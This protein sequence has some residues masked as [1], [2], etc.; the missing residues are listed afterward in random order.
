M[1]ELKVSKE[2]ED[3]KE[4]QPTVMD[5]VDTPSPSVQNVKEFDDS[6]EARQ[7]ERKKRREQRQQEL[8]TVNDTKVHAENGTAPAASSLAVAQEVEKPSTSATNGTAELDSYEARK[9][10]RRKARE[11]RLKAAAARV[12]DEKPKQSY[13]EKKAIEARKNTM[14]SRKQWE[15]REEESGS[16]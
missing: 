10:A 1:E 11:E 16:K 8:A 9:E 5:I 4:E 6:Y 13:K 15:N 12:G 2:D 14:Q 3:E 7:D